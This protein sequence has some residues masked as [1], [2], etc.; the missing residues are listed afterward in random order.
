ML[1]SPFLDREFILNQNDLFSRAT[2]LCHR[3]EQALTCLQNAPEIE[4]KFLKISRIEVRR[5]FSLKH[6]RIITNVLEF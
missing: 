5:N 3:A 1:G 2:F 6:F 4:S